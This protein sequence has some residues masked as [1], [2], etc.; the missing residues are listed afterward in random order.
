MNNFLSGSKSTVIN[1]KVGRVSKMFVRKSAPSLEV[2]SDSECD[3]SN[4]EK[5][6]LSPSQRQLWCF[7]AFFYFNWD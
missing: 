4:S 5:G 1:R 3:S 6:R 2:V 7:L